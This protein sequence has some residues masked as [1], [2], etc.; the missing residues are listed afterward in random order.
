MY[1]FLMALMLWTDPNSSRE[2]TLDEPLQ[3]VVYKV[4]R[5]QDKLLE[6]NKVKIIKQQVTKVS[7]EGDNL[8]II[9]TMELSIPFKDNILT[10]EYSIK[11]SSDSVE[12]F[13]SGESDDLDYFAS[14]IRL[15]RDKENT[16]VENSMWISPKEEISP[17]W[18]DLFARSKTYKLE[19]SLRQLIEGSSGD[20][21]QK[22]KTDRGN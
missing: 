5:Y 6:A 16:R 21:N 4:V 17:R 1:A 13:M 15:S 8:I 19:K 7:K 11:G 12:F 14:Y 3:V 18:L 2:F 20:H 9:G 22:T 10:C